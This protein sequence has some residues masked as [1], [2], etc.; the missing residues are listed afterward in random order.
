VSI[1]GLGISG[2]KTGFFIII[3][4]SFKLIS[5][6]AFPATELQIHAFNVSIFQSSSHDPLILSVFP[7]SQSFCITNAS[8]LPP[9]KPPPF[10]L[11][12]LQYSYEDDE[13][14]QLADTAEHMHLGPQDLTRDE[15]LER[16]AKASDVAP[17]AAKIPLLKGWKVDTENGEDAASK[18]ITCAMGL[19]GR[20]I[21]GIGT[22]KSLWVW[23]YDE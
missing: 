18:L 1:F 20:V 9:R 7:N 19:G 13:T 4:A 22:N 11:D 8:H 10:P 2:F 16:N 17:E 21:V 3:S 23:R 6:N 14:G 12:E 5:I 15:E